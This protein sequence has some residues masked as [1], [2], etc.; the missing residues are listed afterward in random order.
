MA[1]ISIQFYASESELSQWL[2]GWVAAHDL[3]VVGMTFQPFLI[4]RI[5]ASEIN[6]AVRDAS[7]DRFVL[8][9][10]AVSLTAKT[11]SAFEADHADGLVLDVGR[12]S[13]DGLAESWLACRTD[14][15]VALEKWRHIASDLKSKTKQGITAISRENGIAAFYKS[16]RFSQGAAELEKAGIAM[17]ATQ[18]LA[19]PIIR[20]GK[21]TKSKN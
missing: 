10:A 5:P 15:T 16:G 7:V 9:A 3:T 19:G 8:F 11:K 1:D 21:A 20:L 4:S 18:G 12:L 2:T 14:N 13:D 17:I 6:S